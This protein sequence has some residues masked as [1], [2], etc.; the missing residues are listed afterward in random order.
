[1]RVARI[2]GGFVGARLTLSHA[3]APSLSLQALLLTYLEEGIRRCL[4]LP[5]DAPHRDLFVHV[6]PVPLAESLYFHSGQL[7]WLMELGTRVLEHAE[8]RRDRF[9]D[10][11]E[12]AFVSGANA[13]EGVWQRAPVGVK[14]ECHSSSV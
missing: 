5:P 9:K 12:R 10:E 3:A 13:K 6:L 2:G 4:R 11:H 14:A 8:R 7:A 1:M